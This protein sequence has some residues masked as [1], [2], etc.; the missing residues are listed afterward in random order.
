ML[1]GNENEKEYKCELGNHAIS[2]IEVNLNYDDYDDYDSLKI[3][4]YNE[5][6]KSYVDYFY[7]NYY[8]NYNEYLNVEF[9]PNIVIDQGLNIKTILLK[10]DFNEQIE[11]NDIIC[12]KHKSFFKINEKQDNFIQTIDLY[13]YSFELIKNAYISQII[14]SD[15]SSKNYNNNEIFLKRDN[16]YP[17]I[18]FY[19]N[20]SNIKKL[21]FA[22]SIN[23]N[24][25]K[26]RIIQDTS[27]TINYYLNFIPKSN[28]MNI[29][30]NCQKENDIL[31]CEN[32]MYYSNENII[33]SPYTF[34]YNQLSYQLIKV[35]VPQKIFYLN[36]HQN[37][38]L[39]LYLVS[40]DNIFNYNEDVKLIDG[41]NNEITF[42]KGRNEKNGF[43]YKV[44]Y[45]LSL[46]GISTELNYISINGEKISDLEI[47]IIEFSNPMKNIYGS[48]INDKV[49]KIYFEFEK[50]ITYTTLKVGETNINNC[51][52]LIYNKKV[53]Y[54]DILSNSDSP[55]N[56]YY[57]N[58]K[59]EEIQFSENL[60]VNTLEYEYEYD[61]SNQLSSNKDLIDINN[62]KKIK[63]Q[64][65]NSS[66]QKVY[67]LKLTNF[68]SHEISPSVNSNE[69]EFDL[70]QNL[71]TGIYEILL[72]YDNN[73]KIATSSLLK[74][75]NSSEKIVPKFSM[76]NNHLE[77]DVELIPIN[78]YNLT[79]IFDIQISSISL[80]FE[81]K[82]N[83]ILIGKDKINQNYIYIYDGIMNP[84]FSLPRLNIYSSLFVI[85]D[86]SFKLKIENSYIKNNFQ[87]I[88]SESGFYFKIEDNDFMRDQ[89]YSYLVLDKTKPQPQ[90]QS[91][92]KKERI[93]FKLWNDEQY[94]FYL[95]SKYSRNND[96]SPIQMN[97][98]TLIKK[99]VYDSFSSGEI[100][101]LYDRFLLINN[102]EE[103]FN[104]NLRSMTSGIN[105]ISL[106]SHSST[107]TRL[108]LEIMDS[109]EDDSIISFRN[110]DLDIT[111]KYK[112]Y[113]KT[114][115]CDPDTIPD[116]ING[117]FTCKKCEYYNSSKPFANQ[118]KYCSE[119]C[120]EDYKFIFNE[121]GCLR[122]C[123]DFNLFL[124]N[125]KC[126]KECPEGTG[127][128]SENT[129]TCYNCASLG[130]N[131][132]G[133]YCKKC[134]ENECV[135]EVYD[136]K[137]DDEETEEEIIE[138]DDNSELCENYLCYNNGKCRIIDNKAKCICT[139]RYEGEHCDIKVLTEEEKKMNS[140]IDLFLDSTVDGNNI[141][142]INLED[143][144]NYQLVEELTKFFSSPTLV[145]NVEK[146]T[147]K[148]IIHSVDTIVMRI[149]DGTNPPS[150][151]KN[152]M[153]LIDLSLNL[154]LSI[155]KNKKI[156][157]LRILEGNE[158][159]KEEIENIQNL[160]NNAMIIYKNMLIENTIDK[161]KATYNRAESS[162]LYFQSYTENSNSKLQYKQVSHENKLAY[163]DYSECIE[164]PSDNNLYIVLNIPV[165]FTQVNLGEASSFSVKI[166]AFDLTNNLEIDISECKKIKINFPLSNDIDF[167]KYYKFKE[168]GIDIYNSEEKAF[169]DIC[170][171]N[172]K[173]KQDYPYSYRR[174][175]IYSQK[176][177]LGLNNIC[178][179][180]GIDLENK[181]VVMNCEFSENGFGYKIE[182]NKLEE[183]KKV[184]YVPL[185]CY[186]KIINSF[187]QLNKGNTIIGGL[188]ISM[189]IS[190]I[191]SKCC[192]C[193]D[194]EEKEI[195]Q[196][197][198][199]KQNKNN[200]IEEIKEENKEENKEEV[201]NI[202]LYKSNEK[203]KKGKK[204]KNKN[205]IK[206]I[207]NDTTQ[208]LNN[209]EKKNNEK[210][211]DKKITFCII[212]KK[213]FLNS[214]PIFSIFNRKPS[215]MSY[216]FFIFT[217]INYF[218]F[219]ILFYSD[220]LITKRIDNKDRDTYLYPLK[221]QKMKIISSFISSI[222]LTL[223]LKLIA[224]NCYGNNIK[225]QGKAR[226]TFSGLLIILI[227]FFFLFYSS[228]FCYLYQ[229]TQKSF[230]NS[231]V[232]CIIID[233]VLL[234]PIFILIFSLLACKGLKCSHNLS[235]L[236]PL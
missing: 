235:E 177:I 184:N 225:K 114:G 71:K 19:D 18:E 171:V 214:H 3:N 181:V 53:I 47:K 133:N 221:D 215:L 174:T 23:I 222:I 170:Y 201:D 14:F 145:A 150:S 60:I 142:D 63:L 62:P 118:Q 121:K 193:K 152:V 128:I 179:Y 208:R 112:V 182:D 2:K 49:S 13:I 94:S 207:R 190:L 88:K 217:M 29:Y 231:G 84:I 149:V 83:K 30:F 209:E 146:E 100:A 96:D 33:Y 187:K 111:F 218:G 85:D 183:D 109:F 185:K 5:N 143:Q 164:N 131:K 77:S 205:N 195:I 119:Y 51:Y 97:L 7:Y 196:N 38:N 31:N 10:N 93:N 1:F 199:E 15:N 173:L 110:E 41:N 54:C 213:T 227:S 86:E 147:Q 136:D 124:Y 117:E 137:F 236:F 24:Q 204:K 162:I 180:Q 156:L 50:E 76:V 48:L 125:N 140:L 220:N 56:V 127:L 64:I 25:E 141:N 102:D 103:F 212:F 79:N 229:N 188:I 39:T 43:L 67:L 45:S 155:L 223:F 73:I 6:L 68:E 148:K 82:D 197:D 66:I 232:I 26:F 27:K 161:E 37:K 74:I 203:G 35:E 42:T 22:E 138:E 46:N 92:M 95:N 167:D 11:I 159:G 108:S 165:E 58:V 61:Y 69:I 163:A 172:S 12:D 78:D 139:S 160:L 36:E 28:H 8:Y 176:K 191:F 210:N 75:Y 202:V 198:I 132:F 189:F 116:I 178:S 91:L 120:D 20:N 101:Y 219:N 153:K 72:G 123:K 186:K 122:N 144:S 32:N 233:W 59:G 16:D 52:N 65:P 234:S 80:P 175:D 134:S 157:S 216:L 151:N 126:Y 104:S 194:K 135:E 21:F 98:F 115:K 192:C 168:V 226:R 107:T 34:F 228:I 57:T 44:E 87:E 70:P 106:Y 105:Y 211:E 230:M 17:L 169:K 55:L 40:D 206:I 89:R 90:L 224:W 113:N 200:S 9:H 129:F 4:F 81:I 158:D 154:N 130:K 99:E 166:K